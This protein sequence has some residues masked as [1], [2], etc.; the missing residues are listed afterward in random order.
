[1]QRPISDYRRWE[2][3]GIAAFSDVPGGLVRIDLTPSLARAEVFLQGAH[4]ASFQ[5]AGAEPVLFLSGRSRFEKGRAIR[6][7]VPVIFPWF[8]P[9]AG[10][11]DSP[12]HG[13]ARTMPWELE[14]LTCE[15]GATVCLVLAL[16]SSD[17]TRTLWPHEFILRHRI[18]VGSEPSEL[19]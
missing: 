9:R 8:G 5:P 13:F 1:M 19:A 18:S 16:E 10:H 17:A 6:G 11:P 7:G 15:D 2:I 12:A 3:P 14:S 4:V